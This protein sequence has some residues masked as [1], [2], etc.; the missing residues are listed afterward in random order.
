MYNQFKL[1]LAHLN[2]NYIDESAAKIV[3]RN[4]FASVFMYLQGSI[5][6]VLNNV[7]LYRLKDVCLR[8]NDI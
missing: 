8:S 6:E 3:I 2:L 4:Y 1:I 7:S 5:K